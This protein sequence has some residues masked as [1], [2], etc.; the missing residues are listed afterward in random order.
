MY[1][2][3]NKLA[4]WHMSDFPGEQVVLL[5][6][7]GA[8]ASF[9][10]H[11]FLCTFMKLQ[12]PIVLV[13]AAQYFPHYTVTCMKLGANLE[14]HKAAGKLKVVNFLQQS[15]ESCGSCNVSDENTLKDLY[16][17]IKTVVEEEFDT[18]DNGL[19]VIDDLTTFLS[20]GM[21][22]TNVIK[23]MHYVSS[24]C[25]SKKCSFITLIHNDA[26]MDTDYAFYENCRLYADTEIDISGLTS[27]YSKDVTGHLNLTKKTVNFCGRT[28][29]VKKK[30]HYCLNERSLNIFSSGSAGL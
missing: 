16:C 26:V 6:D 4:D 18:F 2:S 5:S 14:K 15:I 12:R 27:G 25:N 23:L 3:L 20:I 22:Y 10:I 29:Y 21:S 13:T 8:D 30:M 7:S 9:V 1:D 28:L 11:H 19:V 17:N 24:L